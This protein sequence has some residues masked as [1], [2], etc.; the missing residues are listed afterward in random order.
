MPL[1]PDPGA[2]IGGR[3]ELVEKAGRGGMADV[4]RSHVCGDFGFRRVLAVKQMHTALAEQGGYVNMFVEEARLGALLES[5][6]IAEV[7]DFIA[8]D[9]NYYIVME[10]IDGVDLGS[11]IRWHMET[12][13][14]PRW[15]LVAA[16]GV[17]ILRGLAAAHERRGPDGQPMPIV[18]RDV[19]P[20]N[21]LLTTRGMVKLIDF[22]LALAPDR[23]HERTEPGIVKGK[24]AYLSPEIVSGGRPVPASD[25]FACG[26]VL[27]ETLVGKKLFDGA[28]DYETYTKVRDCQVPPLRPLRADVPAPFSQIVM[29]AL[30]P[31]ADARFPSTRE[32]ARQIGTVMKKVTMRRDMHTVLARSVHEVLGM[33][34]TGE[35]RTSR[36]ASS[37]TPVAD[38][39]EYTPPL[40]QDRR[41]LWHKLPFFGRRRG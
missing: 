9:G 12:G 21:V 27:W 38:F 22:G 40:E 5:P 30:S 25:Q 23:P 10:W 20:H 34:N 35:L 31:T 19:S 32:M 8:E 36:D 15:E 2:I 29:R 28:T 16:I 41:G 4:W 26:S 7:R 6:N 14:A 39:R 18:H 37:E 3:Y 11:W 17:G 13:Q 24:M 33:I 1:E